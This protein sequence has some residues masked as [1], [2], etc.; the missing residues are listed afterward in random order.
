MKS[1]RRRQIERNRRRGLA[2]VELVLALPVWMLLAS[3]MV[4]VGNLGAWKIRGHLAAREA[5]VRGQWPR[6]RGTDANSAE[7]RRPSAMMQV[8]PTSSPAV[9]DPL[10]GHAVIRGPQIDSLASGVGVAVNPQAMETRPEAA[11]GEAFLNEPPAVWRRSG[12]RNR[13][14]REFAI[15]NGNAGQWIPSAS[16]RLRCQRVWALPVLE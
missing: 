9:D 10:A 6:T 1:S 13:F 8:R 15:L 14:A 7:W 2:P 16:E 3:A 11:M 5:A 4:I 12:V